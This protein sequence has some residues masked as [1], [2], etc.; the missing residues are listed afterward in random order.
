MQIII[1]HPRLSEARTLTITPRFAAGMIAAIGAALILGAVLLNYA[2]SGISWP[3]SG[4]GQSERA[5]EE[6]RQQAVLRENINLLAKRV[7]EMQAKLMQLDALGERVAGLAGVSPAFSAKGVPGRGGL[8]VSPQPM[9]PQDVSSELDHLEAQLAERSDYLSVLDAQLT[10]LSVRKAMTPTVMPVTQGYNGSSFG[11]RVDPFTG[12]RSLHEGV[13]FAAPSGTS[14]VAAAGGV[15]QVA[16]FHSGYGYMI[17]ID[18]G[19][20]LVTRYAH[21]SKLL[22]KPGDLVKRGQRIAAV[23]STGRSTGSHLH[24][25]VRLGGVAVNPNNFLT[26]GPGKQPVEPFSKVVTLPAPGPL[27]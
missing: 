7:G 25:E 21:A 1:V 10:T 13:D 23:G 18:H 12:T 19:N 8:L 9:S 14:I 5:R 22:V 4:S 15:V 3:W 20:D 24:F 11:W 6:A 16:E 2:A 26:H 27:D 17:D